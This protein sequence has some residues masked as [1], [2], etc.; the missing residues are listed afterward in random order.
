M[1]GFENTIEI[2]KL[3]GDVQ[4][5]WDKNLTEMLVKWAEE[6]EAK[7]L[8]AKKALLL[9]KDEQAKLGVA[10]KSCPVF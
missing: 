1:T 3:S 9:F 4:A 5:S 6:L 2:E 10:F 7:G 8:M